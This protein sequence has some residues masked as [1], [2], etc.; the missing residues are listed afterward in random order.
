MLCATCEGNILSCSFSHCGK[1]SYIHCGVEQSGQLV[2]LITRRSVVQ[3]RP[4][5]PTVIAGQTVVL[6]AFLYSW[7]H[8]HQGAFGSACA[9]PP[10][11]N[12]LSLLFVPHHLVSL[13]CSNLLF[14]LRCWSAVRQVGSLVWGL[15]V[16]LSARRL[17][18]PSGHPPHLS[19]C[20]RLEFDTNSRLSVPIGDDFP[21]AF[22]GA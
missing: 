11:R 9:E 10:E 2:G 18:K 13:W 7:V 20:W 21:I 15:A 12:L 14:R 17:G 1:A 16:S 3:I 5:R 22:L 6:P 19:A 4:P 8:E